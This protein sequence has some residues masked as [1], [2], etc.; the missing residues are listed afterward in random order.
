[1]NAI[2]HSLFV[3][4]VLS[5]GLPALAAPAQLEV[6]YETEA[7]RD[8]AIEQ[9]PFRVV[10]GY[11][12]VDFD[13]GPTDNNL[14]LAFYY[15][16]Q[17][18]LTAVDTAVMYAGIEFVD[19]DADGTPEVVVQTFT[20]GAHCCQMYTTYTWQAGQFT[21][22]YFGPLDGGGGRFE[23]LNGDGRLEFITAD[24][25]FFYAFGPYVT[26]YPPQVILSYD[27]GQF[28]DVTAQFPRVL[29][30]IAE[31]MRQIVDDSDFAQ[32]GAV[33]GVLAGYVAQAIRLE[34][35]REAWQYMLARYNRDD[36]WGLDIYDDSGTVVYQHP[37]FPSALYYFLQDLGYLDDSGR[38]QPGADRS[39]VIPDREI[40]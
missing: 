8:R 33:N 5:L 25:A 22:T 20:G 39:P 40:F 2:H 23:D 13:G 15:N 18:T 24:N 3:G 4:A 35:Y 10:V 27:Q 21:P 31:E 12:P 32:W 6:T 14:T 30:P 28:H 17:L 7:F 38:P 37:D 29:T 11:Q 36:D 16:D 34:H 26:S 19:L 9:G 1:M